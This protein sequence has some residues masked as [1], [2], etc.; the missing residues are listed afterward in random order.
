M[1]LREAGGRVLRVLSSVVEDTA[2]AQDCSVIA[3]G[4]LQQPF[5][6]N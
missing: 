4:K 3:N 2:G 5:S 6:G 1:I